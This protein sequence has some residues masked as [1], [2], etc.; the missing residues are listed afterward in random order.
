MG[1]GPICFSTLRV[2]SGFCPW[3]H[4]ENEKG[5]GE[6]KRIKREREARVMG[7][8]ICNRVSGPGRALVE[9]SESLNIHGN[10]IELCPSRHH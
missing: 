1:S 6:R 8:G 3:G 7:T 5:K 10:T 4:S 9:D 2:W